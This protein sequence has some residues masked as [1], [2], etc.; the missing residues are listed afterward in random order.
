MQSLESITIV[1]HTI[2]QV[3]AQKCNDLTK[4]NSSQSAAA[5]VVAATDGCPASED[6]LR[7]DLEPIE[8]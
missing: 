5:R 1:K 4:T 8:P 2:L 3:V 7:N 6:D